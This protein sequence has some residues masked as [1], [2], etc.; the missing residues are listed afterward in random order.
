MKTSETIKAVYP[1]L[2]EVQKEIKNVEKEGKNTFFKDAKYV[3][4]PTVLDTVRPILNKH[5]LVLIQGAESKDGSPLVNTRLVHSE[6]GEWVETESY[7][8]A[9]KVGPQG[10]GSAIT[11]LRRYSLMALLGI[12]GE[13]DDDANLAQARSGA[14]DKKGGGISL[15]ERLAKLPVD[16]KD[17]MAKAGCNTF[18]QRYQL[19]TSVA[20]NNEVAK[21]KCM[22]EIK[23]K[24][25]G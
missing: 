10:Y 18:Q 24:E 2:L 1:A 25:K 9:D 19:M 21:K 11:Y 8:Q 22:E 3:T 12:S 20:W 17:I 23:K 7:V 14:T 6:S 4:L 13:A 5:G 15:P 16:L